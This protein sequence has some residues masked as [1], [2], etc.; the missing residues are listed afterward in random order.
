MLLLLPA[1]FARDGTGEAATIPVAGYFTALGLAY[2]LVEL[3]FL[4]A[5]ILVLGD[6]ILAAGL[7]IGGFSFFSGIGS[8]VSGR[9]ESERTM[10]RVF[11]GIA[12]CVVAGFVA[13]S[14][15]AGPLLARGWAV[16][17]A[18]FVAALAPAAFLMGIP[19]PAAISRLAA[20]GGSAI[21][22]AWAV[23]GFFSVAGASL[24]SIGALWLGFRWTIVT[25]AI[26]YVM[27]GLLYWRIGRET[28]VRADIPAD[29]SRPR[30][31][32]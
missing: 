5:G 12:I 6:P 18:V 26:L 24:A 20:A 31:D 1:A 30:G 17:T 4:K 13:L 15:A 29:G 32:G 10:R 16:R 8:A 19:F 11:A 2:M 23:N 22:F 9:W 27:A 7:A 28:A 3:T 14:A 25:G 21:P